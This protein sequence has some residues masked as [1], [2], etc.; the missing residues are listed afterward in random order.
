[1]AFVP[2]LKI[3]MGGL[4]GKSATLK[5]PLEPKKTFEATRGHIE[6]DIDACIFC[7][8]CQRKCPTGAISVSKPETSWSIARYDC[9]QCNCCAEVCPKKCLRMD[10]NPPGVMNKQQVHTVKQNA[11]V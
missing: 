9:M 8:M 10:R 11:R 4:F 5:F 7:G 1:M 2:I 6:I 3:I